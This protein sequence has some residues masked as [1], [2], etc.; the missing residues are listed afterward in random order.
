[1]KRLIYILVRDFKLMVIK[2]EKSERIKNVAYINIKDE[3]N[4]N[5]QL[6]AR[7]YVIIL[8]VLFNSFHLIMSEYQF[9]TSFSTQFVL[10]QDR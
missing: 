10:T 5:I 6:D 7:N 8:M 9:I 3:S 2:D 1:M 4:T